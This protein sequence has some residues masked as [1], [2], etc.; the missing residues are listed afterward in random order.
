MTF[1][2]R[3]RVL[4]FLTVMFSR[5]GSM[6]RILVLRS[7][8]LQLS[9]SSEA[10]CAGGMWPNTPSLPVTIT[11]FKKIEKFTTWNFHKFLKIKG[12]FNYN[13]IFQRIQGKE[14]A[15]CENS[16]CTYFVFDTFP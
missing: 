16:I 5:L 9:S 8:C 14:G 2:W 15:R 4:T 3:M 12:S 13:Y 10:V 1:W 6:L 7:T 11:H